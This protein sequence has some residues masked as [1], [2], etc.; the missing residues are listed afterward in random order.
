MRV[1][2]VEPYYA[3]SHRAWAD[4]FLQ[5]SAHEARL[6][7]HP[8]RWW[9]WRMRGA[10]VTLAAG[11]ESL[12]GWRPDVVMVSDMIDLAHFRTLSRPSIGDAPMALYFHESQLTY[13]NPPGTASDDS[14]ALTN[15][16]SALSADQV[17][18]NSGYH[19]NVFFH[20]VPDLLRRFPDHRH[21]HLIAD[22][23]TR[24]SGPGA[25]GGQRILPALLSG[26][27]GTTRARASGSRAVAA[28]T[29][30]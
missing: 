23:Q 6:T 14:Y 22:V 11:L 21:L 5:H 30:R 16:I 18:F 28:N 25:I 20:S 27:K 19:R 15:W 24:S 3:G 1:L 29:G 13:P 26:R 2:L 9:K 8:G 4:G 10:A 12:G 7:A 17:F